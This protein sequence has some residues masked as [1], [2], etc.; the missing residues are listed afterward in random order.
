MLPRDT[1]ADTGEVA[2]GQR[3]SEESRGHFIAGED[4]HHVRPIA[5]DVQVDL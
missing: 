2:A 3:P 1:E 5:V 4:V